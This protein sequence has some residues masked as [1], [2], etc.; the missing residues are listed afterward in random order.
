MKATFTELL[1][2]SHAGRSLLRQE[3]TRKKTAGGFNRIA[4]TEASVATR[5]ITLIDAE[6]TM[7]NLPIIP[8]DGSSVPKE[9]KGEEINSNITGTTNFLCPE[10]GEEWSA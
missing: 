1:Q 6:L 10:C 3:R 2:D 8:V 5:H 9:S 7:R 4:N